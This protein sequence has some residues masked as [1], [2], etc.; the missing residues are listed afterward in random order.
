VNLSGI[1][2]TLAMRRKQQR[3]QIRKGLASRE[4][5]G[6]GLTTAIAFPDAWISV[7]RPDTVVEETSSRL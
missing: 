6:E 2:C 5:Q 1:A 3:I 7:P 4:E